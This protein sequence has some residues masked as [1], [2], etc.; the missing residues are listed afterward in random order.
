MLGRGRDCQPCGELL[1]TRTE[2]PFRCGRDGGVPVL[3]LNAG[4]VVRASLA[5][6]GR[7]RGW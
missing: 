4:L 5:P 1:I 7:R 2:P 6:P 3:V